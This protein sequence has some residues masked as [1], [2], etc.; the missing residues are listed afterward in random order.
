MNQRELAQ[1]RAFDFRVL[2]GMRSRAFDFEA[3]RTMA[4]LER[5]LRPVTDPAEGS[6]VSKYRW[7]FR[8][9]T[10]ISRTEFAP[11]T[12]IGVNTDVTDYPYSPPHTWILSS[13]VPWSPHFMRNAP[14]CIGFELWAPTA[15]HITLGELAINIA[16]LLNWDEKGRGPGYSGWNRAAIEHHR[17][18]YRGRPI[19]PGLRY[20][21]LPSWL[22]GEQAAE[23]GFQVMGEAGVADPGFQVQR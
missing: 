20:P 21:V 22:S 13:H 8:V 12:E 2:T 1:R 23:P 6:A 15:G 14:V 7:L 19:D 9:R 4:D 10:H 5:R 3:Y 11:E 17:T 18:F 16:H